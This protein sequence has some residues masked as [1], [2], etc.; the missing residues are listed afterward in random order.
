MSN[1]AS[2]DIPGAFPGDDGKDR[3]SRS[4]SPLQNFLVEK[5]TALSPTRLI[6]H[7]FSSASVIGK[8]GL[9]SGLEALRLSRPDSP[10]SSGRTREETLGKDYGRPVDGM[11]KSIV[12][13]LTAASMYAGLTEFEAGQG[14]EVLAE[15]EIVT[16][17]TSEAGLG[18][19]GEAGGPAESYGEP[20]GGVSGALGVASSKPVESYEPTTDEPSIPPPVVQSTNPLDSMNQLRRR[21]TL[22]ELSV[23]NKL[24]S[25]T[26]DSCTSQER[27]SA[28]SAKLQ[29]TFDIAPND[30]FINDYPCW[31]LRD[32]LLQ[33]HLYITKFHVL[34]FAYLPKKQGSIAKRGSLSVKSYPSHRLHRKWAILRD[35]T[36][37][38]YSDSTELYFPSLVLD[39]RYALRAEIVHEGKDPNVA[40][41]FR[42]ITES[43]SYSF[44][45]DSL[46]A[47]RGWV[48][49]IK[50][51]IFS[52]RNKKGHATIKMPLK[53][54][55]DVQ[56]DTILGNAQSVK[57]KVLESSESFALDDYFLIFFN[58]ATNV[59]ADIDQV[60]KDD[61]AAASRE[62]SDSTESVVESIV[63]PEQETEPIVEDDDESRYRLSK[64]TGSAKSLVQGI[65]NIPT[66]LTHNLWKTSFFHYDDRIAMEMGQDSNLVMDSK[67]RSI[68]NSRFR[69]HFQLPETETLISV[70]YAHLQRNIPL[71]G[72][73]YI[74]T[75]EICY[76]SLIPGTKTLMILP[77]SDIET[78]HKEKGFR[79]GY[80]GLVVVIH[81]HEELFFEFGSSESR[82][83]CE[84]VLLKQV[85]KFRVVS[86]STSESSDDVRLAD[87]PRNPIADARLRLFE[88]KMNDFVGVDVPIIVEDDP[89]EE[90]VFKPSKSYRFT[91]LT[92][93]SRGDVQPYIALGKG[94]LAEGHQVKIATHK[95]FEGWILSHGLQ[96]AEIA[97]DP[98][99]LMS[100]M[101]QHG[102]MSVAFLKDASS[103]FRGWISELLA[104]SW[105]ACQDTDVLIESPS[106][107]GGLHIAEKLKIP[108]FRAF[109]MP[110]TK[111]R[112]YPHAFI[113]PDQ[114]R[115][116]SYNYLTHV[117]FE[118]VFWKGISG[119]V[120]K[121]RVETLKLKKTNL[122]RMKQYKVPFMYNVSP[123][124][125]PPSVDFA[126]WVN[127]T[128]YW[129]L[130]EANHFEPN[131]AL[132]E[133]IAKARSDGKK[134]VYIGFGS[135]VVSDPKELTQAVVDAVVDAD[136]RCILNKGWSDRLG[137][138]T[139]IEV[140]LPEQVYNAGSVPHDW[141]FPQIDACVHHGG[142]GTTGAS[143]RA[144]LPT[145][146]KPFF[147]DQFFYAGRVEDMGAGF[148]LRKLNAKSLSKLLRQAVSDRRVIETARAVSE[149][150]R[151]EN[152]VEKAIEIIYTEMEYARKLSVS[153]QG[154]DEP[155][156]EESL[157]SW[158]LV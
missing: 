21:P 103:R 107:M 104:S 76:R 123:T 54:V 69:E 11:A 84:H 87:S 68:S 8:R 30:E 46:D 147:G 22:F 120:N 67:Q 48:S 78:V 143:M 20:V 39:L 83:D 122:S 155:E 88:N 141:L 137:A 112:A 94:L 2:K 100:L 85:D 73:I 32:V 158:L 116:G 110:W 92:I 142:S 35:N 62:L 59:V 150:I 65:V 133:F 34:F 96:F 128:G 4:R 37:S 28:I 17:E 154:D 23:V 152:G 156:E 40:T 75:N 70:Y 31:L 18:E 71:Y 51:Q 63:K 121:W 25:A 29:Q 124:V 24:T 33:G 38:L 36:F 43:R 66:N 97:G 42:I 130:D 53:N 111:T 50:K 45:A 41:W 26:K 80:S 140:E 108:Y 64:L 10:L 146:I 86:E 60:W 72:K 113:V 5:S 61:D 138:K 135:I 153:K 118:N 79:F 81:G 127:V 82:D 106:A 57:I 102:T 19:P 125:L 15:D 101:V 115:G 149:K 13:M 148:F 93:G 9:S 44:E 56:L 47:A 3:P 1:D 95:E 27:A 90:T 105:E 6:S 7:S 74:G 132:V 134:V 98:A 117:M 58:G 114:K 151:R 77:F 49:V 12:T 157:D 119:Q 109:T 145:I 16:D 52:A 131:K 99:E 14:D 144:G 129:F 91:L 136:V 89:Y 139:E 55:M 126:E